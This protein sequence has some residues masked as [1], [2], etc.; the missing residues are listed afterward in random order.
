MFRPYAPICRTPGCAAR[1]RAHERASRASRPTHR[2][3]RQP[4]SPGNGQS[5]FDTVD[6]RS[7]RPDLCLSDGARRFHIKDD[8]VVEIDQIIRSIGEEGVPFER[9]RHCAAGSDGETNFGMLSLAAPNAA[10]SS[11]A[12]Y[13]CAARHAFGPM[14]AAFHSLLGSERCLLASAAMRLASTAKPSPPIKPSCRQRP[15]RTRTG[16][17]GCCSPGTSRGDCVRRSSDPAPCRSNRDD[18]TTD[19]RD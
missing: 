13:S 11:V 12:R 1:S 4:T 17:A 9:S 16:A 10:S 2:R 5:A 6:H 7:G 14:P 18:R 8:R 19:K 3:D 15:R